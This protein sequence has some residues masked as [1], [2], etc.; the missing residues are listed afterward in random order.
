MSVRVATM[1]SLTQTS[2]AVSRLFHFLLNVIW[3]SG[4]SPFVL[5]RF[6][7]AIHVLHSA[8]VVFSSTVSY[9]DASA[10]LQHFE[11]STVSHSLNDKD[12]ISCSAHDQAIRVRARRTFK[13]DIKRYFLTTRSPDFVDN[14]RTSLHYNDS[15][16]DSRT[17]YQRETSFENDTVVMIRYWYITLCYSQISWRSKIQ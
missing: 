15:R 14:P 2:Y 17:R 7:D 9:S 4:Q 11:A 6:S 5:T 1:S 13:Y 3:F 12:E 16:F 10:R 8:R